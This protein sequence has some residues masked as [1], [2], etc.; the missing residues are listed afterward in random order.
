MNVKGK[1]KK[2]KFCL[3]EKQ[4]F[5]LVGTLLGDGNLAKRGKYCRLFVKHS[6][7]QEKLIQWKYNIF[8]DITLMPLNYF[9]QNVYGKEYQFIQFATLTHPIF[10]EYRNVFYRGVRKIIP[11][12]ID[13]VFYHPLSLT[14]LLMDDGANDT[15][16]MTLQTHCF[17]KKEVILLAKSIKKNFKLN[18][19]LRKN[20]GKWII[21]FPKVEIPK[22]YKTIEEYLLPSSK[23]KFPMTP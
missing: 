10:D 9:A 23:Y 21:Y 15:F 16:G 17:A 22:L 3:S 13:K 4:K 14:V 12:N 1:E 7:N 11:S 8:K 2:A 6:A 18:T 20:K 5:V 19:S